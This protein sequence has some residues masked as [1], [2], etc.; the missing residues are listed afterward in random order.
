M[1]EMTE[2]TQG[3][4]S[5]INNGCFGDVEKKRDVCFSF[6]PTFVLFEQFILFLLFE[7]FKNQML[8][9][10]CRHT[11]LLNNKINL[12]SGLRIFLNSLFNK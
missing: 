4:S 5:N 3:H 7:H 2:H 6:F 12:T 9:L 10:F 1:N 8:K 11:N